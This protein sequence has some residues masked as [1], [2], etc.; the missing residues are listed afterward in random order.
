MTNQF[1]QSLNTSQNHI[2]L[3]SLYMSLFKRKY[4]IVIFSVSVCLLTLIMAALSPTRYVA[5][6][7]LKINHKQ[8]HI[9]SLIPNANQ[10]LGLAN[11]SEDSLAVLTALIQSEY[12]LRPVITSLGLV[13]SSPQDE[14]EMIEKLRRK[15]KIADL[16]GTQDN[17][18]NKTAIIRISLQGDQP[19]LI[20]KIL[21]QIAYITQQQNALFMR[22][23]AD[24][25]LNFL[26]QQL[27]SVKL[28]LKDAETKLNQYRM[29]HGRVDI[30]SQTEFLLKHLSD[31][32]Q[33]LD[34][35]YLKKSNLLQRYT[36][37]HPSVIT[38]LEEINTLQQARTQINLQLKQLPYSEQEETT[39]N[40]EVEVKNNLYMLLLNQ[41]HEL[42]VIK[43][44]VMS[45]VEILTPKVIPYK[46][47]SIPLFIIG[48]IGLLFGFLLAC[49]LAL[50]EKLI[51]Q[52]HTLISAL[53][54]PHVLNHAQNE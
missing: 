17:I 15:L 36:L 1:L 4:F 6:V 42:N 46:M 20:S 44:G 37:K 39:L 24:K 49:M 13:K 2:D 7:L 8:H 16:S 47:S 40:R 34:N 53:P 5:S 26:K 29:M 21:M 35:L 43:K 52:S 23:E 28:S 9:L 25:T 45:D 33:Q 31:I 27:P 10:Q 50:I 22:K 3:K 38:T 14:F 11:L 48:F 18:N 54:T 30:K 41:I 19:L 32:N 51:L 12:I